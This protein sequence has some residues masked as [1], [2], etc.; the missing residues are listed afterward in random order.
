M[1]TYKDMAMRERPKVLVGVGVGGKLI[2]NKYAT[3]DEA[4]D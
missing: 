3:L 1:E 4:L 2:G